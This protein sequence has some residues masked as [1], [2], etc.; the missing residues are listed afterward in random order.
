MVPEVPQ[1][2]MLLPARVLAAER[3]GAGS[4][5][6][7]NGVNTTPIQETVAIDNYLW[8]ALPIVNPFSHSSLSAILLLTHRNTLKP[9]VQ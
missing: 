4:I 3:E 5:Y 7:A 2:P 9:W 8:M 1:N 6:P